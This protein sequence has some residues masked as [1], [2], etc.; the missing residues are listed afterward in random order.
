L[1][2]WVGSKIQKFEFPSYFVFLS[3]LFRLTNNPDSDVAQYQE[4]PFAYKKKKIS[5]W[6]NKRSTCSR[7]QVGKNTRLLFCN[8]PKIPFWWKALFYFSAD[9]IF[10]WKQFQNSY[11]LSS[12]S[13]V[14]FFLMSF[15]FFSLTLFFHFPWSSS[16]LL[17]SF[18]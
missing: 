6:E 14:N 18:T 8:F 11:S 17:S 3:I 9:I 15:Q 5:L 12:I 10:Y 16:H 1:V 4:G 2:S 13:W 7:N